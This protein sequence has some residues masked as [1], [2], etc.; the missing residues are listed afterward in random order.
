MYLGHVLLLVVVASFLYGPMHLRRGHVKPEFHIFSK[1]CFLLNYAIL[2]TGVIYMNIMKIF[3]M[4][5]SVMLTL[6][7]RANVLLARVLILIQ[8]LTEIMCPYHLKVNRNSVVSI[9]YP[10]L[11][12]SKT[13]KAILMSS[14]D[15]P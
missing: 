13:F 3:I 4:T 2:N 8:L 11:Q 15:P 1:N 14:L 6:C 7:S 5:S 10:C 9:D 12:I